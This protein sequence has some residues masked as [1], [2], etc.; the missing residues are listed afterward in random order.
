MCSLINDREYTVDEIKLLD[1]QLAVKKVL[2]KYDRISVSDD[3]FAVI[4]N[5]LVKNNVVYSSIR[6]PELKISTLIVV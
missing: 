3:D 2:N 1:I 6:D 4:Q 5:I